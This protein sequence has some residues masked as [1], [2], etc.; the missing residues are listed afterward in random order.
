MTTR[1]IRTQ[2]LLG[3]GGVVML[4]V[5]L[6]AVAVWRLI[7]LPAENELAARDMRYAATAASS[8]V[9]SLVEG[10]ERIV[11]TARQWGQSGQLSIGNHEQFNHL[12]LPLIR[13]RPEIDGA[14]FANDDGQEIF[15]LRTERGWDNALTDVVKHP[16]AQRWVHWDGAGR[17]LGEE[18][19]GSDYDPR[20]RPWFIGALALTS[21]DGVYWTEPYVFFTL[22]ELGITTSARWTDPHTRK[23]Y[24]IAFDITLRNLSRLTDTLGIGQGGRVAILSEDE[25]LLSMPR[26]PLIRGPEDAKARLLKT[27]AEAGFKML[28]AALPLWEAAGRPASTPLQFT[29][30]GELWYAHFDTVPIGAT[31]F[32][33]EAVAPRSD[34]VLGRPWHLAAVAAIF[35]VA[36]VVAMLSANVGARRFA[37]T[38]R[39]LTRESERIGNLDLERPVAVRARSSELVAL[40][41]AQEKMRQALLEATRDLERKVEVRTREIQ[42]AQAALRAAMEEQ[43]AVFESATMGIALIRNR[44]IDN[45]NRKLE[46]LFGYDPGEF[47]GQPTRIW[48]TSDEEY[49]RGGDAVYAQLARGKTDQREQQLQRKDGSRFWCRLSGRA[50][51][52]ADLDKGTVWIIDDVTAEHEAAEAMREAR[53]IAEEATQAKSAFLANM[54]HEIRTPMNAIIGLS[55]LALKT[56]LEVKQRDYVSK[57]HNAGTSLLGIINDILD[58]SKVEAGKLSIE[59]VQF[60]LDEVL[61]TASSLVAQKAADK[62]LEL[63]FDVAPDVPQGLIGDPLR[64]GQILTNLLSNA[65]KFT[66]HGEIGV[67]IRCAE[68]TGEKVQLRV[69]VADT[70]IGMTREQAVQVFQAFSQADSSTTRKYGGTGLGLAISRRLVELMGGTIW[71]ESEPAVGSTFGFTAWFGVGNEDAGRRRVLPAALNGARTLVADDNP[72]A[73]E[74]LGELLRTLGL[75]V[76]AVASGEE[77]LD[78]IRQADRDHP[79]DLVLLDWKMAGLD[80]IETARR[81]RRE[82]TAPHPLRL[83]MVTAFGREDLRA[84]ADAAGIDAFLVKPVSRST[85]VDTLVG[86]FA[87]QRSEIAHAAAVAAD[88][89]PAL[90]GARVLLAEDNEIN[91]QIAVE[92][93]EGAGVTVD[94]AATGREVLEQL[95]RT[96]QAY[97]AVLMDL[98]MPDMDGLEATRRLRAD[99]RFAALPII[100]MTAHAMAEERE[101]CLAAGMVDHIAKP[102]EPQAMF[103]T[104]ARWTKGER[105]ATRIVEHSA[106]A[107]ADLPRIDG[108]DA[109]AG[110]RR[111]GGNRDLYLRLLRRFSGSQAEAAR[112]VREALA[113]GQRAAAEHEAHTVKGVAANLGLRALSELAAELERAVRTAEGEELALAA[114]EPALATAVAALAALPGPEGERAT[115]P[116]AVAPAGA[117]ELGELARLLEAGDGEA[118]DYLADQEA[119]LRAAF[120]NGEFAAIEQAVQGYEF[121]VALER[122]RAAAARA[123]I[124]LRERS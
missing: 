89:Q 36:L 76:G 67:R 84:E 103:R 54:S 75:S 62:G 49:R 70:G 78:A 72:S 2:L 17:F 109:P 93:L 120:R 16:A 99:A 106:D 30:Q 107:A 82:R 7:L 100:A 74:I 110:L 34:F 65:I 47:A 13:N 83:I 108:L 122:L 90:A 28:A 20:R 61:D 14:L 95:E 112:R 98:Q 55:H 11:G 31:R 92:L 50:V 3:I 35:L 41:A 9:R 87:P 22:R 1:S 86:L 18:T 51:D 8:Q 77:A 38:V 124:D 56:A 116:I 4:T 29:A 59:S 10:I 68:R 64:V 58:F 21:D 113:S 53:R 12:V 88:Q 115:P 101:R 43:N 118:V 85:L 23:R 104:L 57:I 97:D 121:D 32:V 42:N 46:E 33:V 81:I 39:Y 6:F 105:A 24:V 26:H 19:R 102:I 45:C 69:E 94:V 63:V 73:R 71:V 52:P 44:V 5:L 15:L 60:R 91:R 27:P 80:G 37:R 111:V 66:E 25:R 117:P 114:F 40:A 48:Y 119:G 123:G 96:P 79:F